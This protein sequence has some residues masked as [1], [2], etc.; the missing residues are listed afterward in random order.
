MTE[1]TARQA[2]DQASKRPPTREPLS[3]EAVESIAAWLRVIAE[4]TRIRL[5]EILNGGAVS[6]RRLASQL[7]TSHQNVSRHLCVLHQAGIVRRRKVK[8]STHYELV[9]WSGTW[10]IEQL[11]MSV[12]AEGANQASHSRNCALAQLRV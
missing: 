11:G 9:D 1:H 3:D 2:P 5:M 7:G 12:T 6:V 10:L 8:R 4:P